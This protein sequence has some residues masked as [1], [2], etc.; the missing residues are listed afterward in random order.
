MNENDRVAS[1]DA[2]ADD[3]KVCCNSVER[4]DCCTAAPK[5]C[6]IQSPLPNPCADPCKKMDFTPPRRSSKCCKQQ[7][8]PYFDTCENTKCSYDDFCGPHKDCE[9]ID[10][11][12]CEDQYT[13]IKVS[14]FFFCLFRT[15]V[16]AD[17]TPAPITFRI[18]NFYY[19]S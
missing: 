18:T 17:W 6:T 5:C 10:L 1:L 8:S 7:K 13:S 15:H 3:T 19:Y 14:F 16:A 2:G 11:C 9:N 4:S 12:S